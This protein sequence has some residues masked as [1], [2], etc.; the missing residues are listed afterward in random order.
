[1]TASK[2]RRTRAQVEQLERQIYDVLAAD[3]PQSVRHVFYRL[4]DP[5]LPEPV[6][7]TEH[8]YQQIVHRM[9]GMRRRGDLPYGWVSGRHTARVSRRDLPGCGGIPAGDGRH[10]PGRS[11]A[12][13]G[14]ACR[15]VG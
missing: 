1:M 10:V 7:K 3:N 2:P 15:S 12:R 13:S 5:R 4:T 6:E 9:S 8:G 14:G 11:V